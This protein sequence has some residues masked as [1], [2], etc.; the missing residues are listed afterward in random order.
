MPIKELQPTYCGREEI[1]DAQRIQQNRR[2]IDLLSDGP[3]NGGANG[4]DSDVSA[5][6]PEESSQRSYVHIYTA[7]VPD[8]L[9]SYPIIP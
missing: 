3:E 4:G 7:A 5:L 9:S 6:L 2:G 1:P 8:P